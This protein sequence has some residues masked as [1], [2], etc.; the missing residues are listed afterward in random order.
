MK[1]GFKEGIEFVPKVEVYKGSLHLKPGTSW[2][3]MRE[4]FMDVVATNVAFQ[5]SLGPKLAG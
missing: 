2:W 3:I 1:M 4:D 5:N